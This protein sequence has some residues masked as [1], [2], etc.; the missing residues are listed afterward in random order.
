VNQF[1]I[2]KSFEATLQAPAEIS[3]E[4][5]TAINAMAPE[6]VPPDQIYFAWA[7]L[8]N[9]KLDRSY[10]RF[11]ES[12]LQRFATT[13]VGK[14]LLPG[15]DKSQVP[16]GRWVAGD[17]QRD[18]TGAVLK[19]GFYMPLKSEMATRVRMGVAPYVSI[20]FKAAG[21]Q[22]DL[23]DQPYD[24][25]PHDKGHTYDGKLCTVTY[26]GDPQLVEAV[27]GSLVWLGC[28]VGAQV[29]GAKAAGPFGGHVLEIQHRGG[30]EM[31][32]QEETELRAKVAQLEDDL[33]EKTALVGLAEEGKAYRAWLKS[34]IARKFSAVKGVVDDPETAMILKTLETANLET[35]RAWDAMIQPQFDAK[36]PPQSQSRPLGAGP[37][38]ST[39]APPEGT[40]VPAVFDPHA[41]LKRAY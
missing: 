35:L 36:F 1:Y 26:S 10:E 12:Y 17:V 8:A 9:D 5:M 2:Q 29:T 20:G 7:T 4:I 18:A 40:A 34:E 33:K 38:H 24:G 13:I 6:P 19:A 41:S 21:R 11:P 32:A 23:C 31:T 15:H 22:C 25:C 14:S 16:I 27:E 28:Q 39:I 3:P 30:E 37:G